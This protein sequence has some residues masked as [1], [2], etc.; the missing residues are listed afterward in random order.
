MPLGVKP[1]SERRIGLLRPSEDVSQAQRKAAQCWATRPAMPLRRCSPLRTLCPLKRR[2]PSCD[3]PSKLG[4]EHSRNGPRYLT[5]T[6]NSA[7]SRTSL[8]VTTLLYTTT[9]YLTL[10]QTLRGEVPK[11]YPPAPATTRP[12]GHGAGTEDEKG[13]DAGSLTSFSIDG[14][15]TSVAFSERRE[16][17]LRGS[18]TPCNDRVLLKPYR[19]FSRLVFD[20][21]P[22][23]ASTISYRGDPSG[24]RWLP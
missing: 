1:N 9:V 13:G 15:Y 7:S 21:L 19:G 6:L 12:R 2:R 11:G 4:F 10:R 22:A 5:S 3:P 23:L 24:V 17:L 14:E 20:L 18:A 16:W 8:Q